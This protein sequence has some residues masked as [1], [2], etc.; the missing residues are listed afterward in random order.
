M[1]KLVTWISEAGRQLQSKLQLGESVSK[2]FSRQNNSDETGGKP[3]HPEPAEAQ[4]QGMLNVPEPYAKFVKPLVIFF[5]VVLVY[6]VLGF[7]VVPAVLKA[8]L[9]DIIQQ[10]TGRKASVGKIEFNP[11]KLFASIQDFKILE[12]NGKPFMGFDNLSLKINIFQSIKQL[13]LAIDDVTLNK[14]TVYLAKDSKGKFN[15]EDM[16]AAKPKTKE[17]P[18]KEDGELFPLRL[19][20]LTVKDGKLL[21][22]DSHFAKPVSEEL[23]PINLNISDLS[24]KAQS[25]AKLD[26]NLGVKSGGKLDWKANVGINPVSS[27]GTI[28]L[29]KL[30]LQKLLALA[31]SDTATFDLQGNELFNVDYK[32]DIDK[33]NVK[34]AI[35]KNRFQ[36]R[37]LRFADK[38]PD[39]MLLTTPTFSVETDALVT[40]AGDKVDVEIKK[41]KLDSQ[42]LKFSNQASDPMSVGI[43]L[44]SH[45]SDFKLAQAKDGLK[46]SAG[47]AVTAIKNF[48]FKG[49][50]QQKIEAK[51]P[52]IKLETSY[53]FAKSE[54]AMDV[55]I[56]HGK[57]DLH[58]LHLAE[59]GE[60]TTLIK[61]P[62]FGVQEMA[63]DLKNKEVII[64]QV[65]AK[66]AEFQTWLDKDGVFNYQKLV[67]TPKGKKVDATRPDYATAKTVD[68]K[69]DAQTVAVA[70]KNVKPEKDWLVTIK[71]L[72]LTNFGVNFEDRSLKK[73]KRMTAKPINLKVSNISN[74]PDAKLPF[75][76]DVKLNK[77]GMIKLKGN[78]VVAPLT[79]KVDIDIKTIDLEDFQPYVDK[80]AKV[81]ILDGQFNLDG[82]LALNQSPK[83]PLDVKFKGNSGIASLLT[84]DQIQSKD[85]IKWENLTLKGINV[86]LLANRFSATTL[87]IEKPYARVT[88]RKD[89]TVN[90]SDIMIADKADKSAKP[91]KPVKVAHNKTTQTS[92]P[93]FK[94]D[95]VK[96]VDGSSDFADLSLIMPFAAQIKSLDGGASGISSDEKAIVKVDLKGSAYD[97]APVDINGEISPYLGNYN[98]NLTFDGMPMPLVTPY[99][100]QFAGY[101][102]EKGKLTLGLKYQIQKGKLEASNNILI[103]QLELGEEVDNPN[104]VSLP[105]GLAIA[106]LKDSEGKIKLDV[107]LTGSL[108]DPQFSIGGII[109][110]ALVNVL[111]KIVTAPFNAIASLAGSDEDLS[112]VSFKPGNQALEV[113]ETGKLDSVAKALKEKPVL[114]LEIKGAA[115]EKEDWPALQ[116]DA[117]LDQLK[118]RRADEMTKEE[119]KKVRA[120]HVELTEDDYNDL[121]ADAFIEKFPAMAE[122]SIIGTPKLIAPDAGDFYQVAKQKMQESIKPEP[123][124]LKHLAD[125]RGKAI[126][127]YIVEK[128]GIPNAKVFILDSAVDPKRDGK[129]LVSALSLKV[130]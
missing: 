13:A 84:R 106:L 9:P 126:A 38:S 33:A 115:F 45:E 42:D 91:A 73:P 59:P 108:E 83:K 125:D 99:M 46:L 30:Q 107:P 82:Q 35:K 105:L 62:V 24:T 97:L 19:A 87:L 39:N 36:L 112:T 5:S 70:A 117:L 66:D 49:V 76:L 54:Q 96:I 78:A 113:K 6:A 43:A 27:E 109:V 44:F 16:A 75:Q 94:L 111:T 74:K 104:A 110:D 4:K 12:K 31:L 52:E 23:S 118:K 11:F 123:E 127:K 88:I 72:A 122:K 17:E 1:K 3:S 57:F 15:F 77:T 40:I 129:E 64:D 37:D 98:I 121:L 67:E 89:K 51:A 28:V 18:K 85:L 69:E 114:N 34:A 95:K 8:K 130:N 47:K 120:E 53:Q 29:D 101:K 20:K 60:N 71:D 48:Q 92:K 65:N 50:N 103:D 26:F 14:P 56:S 22:D 10:E 80:F 32:V 102:I 90:F 128:G 93:I 58:D 2:P 7:Y 61:I 68:F 25:K 116:D 124:R 79:A 41:T 55:N 63:V 21:W 119:G 86:D 100:V 81:D